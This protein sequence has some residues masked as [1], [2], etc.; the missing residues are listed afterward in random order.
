MVD[1]LQEPPPT[2]R[3]GITRRGRILVWALPCL[4]VALAFAEVIGGRTL[5]PIDIAAATLPRPA[6]GP[7]PVVENPLRNDVAFEVW[8]FRA[9]VRRALLA[10]D[11]PLW[12]HEL[13]TGQPLLGNIQSAPFS[14][15]TLLAL[16]FQPLRAVGVSAF[17]AAL[18]AAAGAAALARRLGAT[19]VLSCLAGICFALSGWMSAWSGWR[20]AEVAAWLPALILALLEVSRGL[21]YRALAWLSLCIA[22]CLLSGHPG[23]VWLVALATGVVAL[24][25]L[26]RPRV[27]AAVAASCLLGLLIAAP[28]IVA[29]VAAVPE[30]VRAHAVR[31]AQSGSD[32]EPAMLQG[33]VAP[34]AHG[35]PREWTWTGPVGVA[36]NFNELVSWTGVV[37]LVLALAGLVGGPVGL[38]RRARWIVAGGGVA[39][40]V[41]AGVSPFVDIAWWL[42]GLREAHPGRMAL[43]WTL[44]IA[45]AASLSLT[46]ITSSRPQCTLAVVLGVVE[47]VC[48]VLLGTGGGAGERR[49]L[50]VTVVG[51]VAFL[52][53]LLARAPR[54]VVVALALIATA[55]DLTL[56]RLNLVPTFPAHFEVPAAFVTATE[57][58]RRAGG[59][60]VGD[61]PG[62]RANLVAV[63]GV[64]DPR[65]RDPMR[66]VRS[67]RFLLATGWEQGRTSFAE[68]QGVG[69]VTPAVLGYL[70]VRWLVGPLGH[71]PPR[72]WQRVVATD[73]VGLW[74]EP[75]T[76]GLFRVPE[77]IVP[78][79]AIWAAVAR[80]DDFSKTAFVELDQGVAASRQ[81]PGAVAVVQRPNG[82]EL[83][84]DSPARAPT[85]VASSV[86]WAPGWRARPG[87]R[88]PGEEARV[89]RVNGAFLGIVAAPGTSR[90]TLEYQPP[91]WTASLWM[92][93][94]GGLVV[95]ALGIRRT[96]D[97]MSRVTRAIVAEGGSRQT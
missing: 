28:A 85:V 94:L 60:I 97:S 93:A 35:S 31:K 39:L 17:L 54:P 18:L 82:F 91:W 49:W 36:S 21:S 92:C 79:R 73:G 22:G 52:A 55:A 15:F 61:G 64:G 45:L 50:L 2:P 96:R 69:S 37:P 41:A 34:L 90:L 20:N 13:G 80:N 43:L 25:S 24:A 51:L 6:G 84:L 48:L 76:L 42:P 67:E 1:R 74:H 86:T 33:A 46:S 12:A 4:F 7:R 16:P 68:L 87:A 66:P 95:V 19:G 71:R 40:L 83:T 29:A 72:R 77:Q 78:S 9:V 70:D 14:P 5:V 47:L 89:V 81:T 26:R 65:G 8:P 53:A 75:T 30:S 44:A 58:A 63:F 56:L 57:E 27:I 23:T 59:R 11:A 62:L 3:E 38:R 10:G 32:L 88:G